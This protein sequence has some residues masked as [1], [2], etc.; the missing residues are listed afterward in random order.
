MCQ[1]SAETCLPRIGLH[2]LHQA[3]TVEWFHSVNTRPM[4]TP[5]KQVLW[6]T[7]LLSGLSLSTENTSSP[8][9]PPPPVTLLTNRSAWKHNHPL[10]SSHTS[11][12]PIHHILLFTTYPECTAA[13]AHN[14]SALNLELWTKEHMSLCHF[15][16]CSAQG[17]HIAHKACLNSF[18]RMGGILPCF[19]HLSLACVCE[20]PDSTLHEH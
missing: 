3:D 8:Q 11:Y 1:S 9:H 2:L 4:S 13:V 5:L 19:S 14:T 6:L 16:S 20:S 7:G 15:I 17:W 18:Y 10:P 12:L